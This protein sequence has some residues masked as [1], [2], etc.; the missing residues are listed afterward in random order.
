M[1]GTLDNAV[2][3]SQ[4]Q[5]SCSNSNNLE[6]DTDSVISRTSSSRSTVSS[7]S[8]TASQSGSSDCGRNFRQPTIF[9]SISD[10]RSF[11][12]KNNNF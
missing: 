6:S 7:I 3:V 11:D 2:V 4:S 8:V 12:S 9:E 10:I 1:Q 5:P